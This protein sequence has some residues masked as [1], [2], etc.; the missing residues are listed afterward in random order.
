M[1]PWGQIAWQVISVVSSGIT[2]YFAGS[3]AA[4][5]NERSPQQIGVVD[6]PLQAPIIE[7]IN[8]TNTRL[9]ALYDQHNDHRSEVHQFLWIGAGIALMLVI[10]VACLL[11]VG[12]CCWCH[13]RK[14][15][16]KLQK[17][18]SFGSPAKSMESLV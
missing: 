16:Q 10:L 5:N 12:C 17:K 4:E 9:D 13:L 11:G 3:I 2:G 14:V 6:Q 1:V 7:I 8:S 18:P 15:N